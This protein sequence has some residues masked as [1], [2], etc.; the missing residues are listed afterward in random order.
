MMNRTPTKTIT[1]FQTPFEIIY[2]KK[3]DPFRWRMFGCV[4]IVHIPTEVRN[5]EAVKDTKKQKNVPKI[6]TGSKLG[7]AAE[8]MVLIGYT[9]RVS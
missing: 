6:A 1:A 2:K 3:P 7:P 8:L 9:S 5:R 4:A